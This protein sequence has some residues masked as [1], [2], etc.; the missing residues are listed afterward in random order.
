M[1]NERLDLESFGVHL[2][3]LDCVSGLCAA[4]QAH[5]SEAFGSA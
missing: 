3:P 4:V 1:K 2:L 5:L